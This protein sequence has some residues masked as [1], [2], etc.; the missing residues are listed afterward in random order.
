[1]NVTKTLVFYQEK[2]ISSEIT[3]ILNLTSFKSIQ[4]EELIEN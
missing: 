4:N 1:M 2:D 3:K